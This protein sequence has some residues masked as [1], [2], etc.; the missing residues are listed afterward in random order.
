M[1]VNVYSNMY[2]SQNSLT[3]HRASH[4]KFLRMFGGVRKKMIDYDTVYDAL[5][6]LGLDADYDL[7]EL[8]DARRSAVVKYHP[9]RYSSP[10][11]KQA[12]SVIMSDINRAIS[13]LKTAYPV[14]VDDYYDY[15]S[16]HRLESSAANDNDDEYYDYSD[17][18]LYDADYDDYDDSYY[19]DEYDDYDDYDREAPPDIWSPDYASYIMALNDARRARTMRRS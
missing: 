1:L 13:D 2:R 14:D 10:N 17:D 12:A 15:M 8:D 11:D 18:N 19:D 3:V 7:S 4:D 16:R 5:K 9:D 6:L